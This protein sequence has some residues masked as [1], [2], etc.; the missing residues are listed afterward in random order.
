MYEYHVAKL[1]ES[2]DWRKIPFKPEDKEIWLQ[3]AAAIRRSQVYITKPKAQ[4]IARVQSLLVHNGVM[5][6]QEFV[7]A[8]QRSTQPDRPA[9]RAMV[10]LKIVSITKLGIEVDCGSE[11]CWILTA[12]SLQNMVENW[13]GFANLNQYF[14]DLYSE[15]FCVMYIKSDLMREIKQRW[16]DL[17]SDA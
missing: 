9:D 10:A 12:N 16:L 3:C 11:G 1:E 6:D 14:D 13:N 17:N 5:T 2:D 7:D 15:D 4:L 8:M